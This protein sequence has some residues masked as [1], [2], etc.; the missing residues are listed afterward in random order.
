VDREQLGNSFTFS[1]K[2]KTAAIH[3]HPPAETLTKPP[4]LHYTGLTMKT[5]SVAKRL[6][7]VTNLVYFNWD[8]VRHT[9]AFRCVQP[10]QRGLAEA[11]V[12]MK[13]SRSMPKAAPQPLEPLLELRW[14]FS[15][16]CQTLLPCQRLPLLE[17]LLFRN[18][19]VDTVELESVSFVE[20]YAEKTIA[21]QAANRKHIYPPPP[22]V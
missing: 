14:I 1:T 17:Q 10:T 6:S 13:I 18:A 7:A 11:F 4:P 2:S 21:P 8:K 16:Q 22:Q 5:L 12:P 15:F 19:H 9:G 3:R 20:F